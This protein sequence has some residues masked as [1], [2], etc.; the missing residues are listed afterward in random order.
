MTVA[1]FVENLFVPGH[2]ATKEV[3][4]RA[5]CRAILKHVLTPEEVDR[6]F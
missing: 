2:V 6:A 1:A 4:G 5:H 3:T